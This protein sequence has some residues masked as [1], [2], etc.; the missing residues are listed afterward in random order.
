[1]LSLLYQGFA[2]DLR[3]LGATQITIGRDVGDQRE[4][5]EDHMAKIS[6]IGQKSGIGTKLTKS[7]VRSMV[8]FAGRADISIDCRTITVYEYTPR[9]RLQFPLGRKRDLRMPA[10]V[11]ALS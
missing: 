6:R 7:D 2:E 4:C 8:A 3:R 11:P 10:G 1:V 5:E 9:E